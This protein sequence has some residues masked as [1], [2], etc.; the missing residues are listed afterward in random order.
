MFILK[1]WKTRVRAMQLILILH[2]LPLESE[3]LAETR[4]SM[5][6]QSKNREKKITMQK[7]SDLISTSCEGAVHLSS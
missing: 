2:F 1:Q 5:Q 6:K 4:P 3:A 7:S